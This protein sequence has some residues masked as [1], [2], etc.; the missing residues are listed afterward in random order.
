MPD[1]AL[2]CAAQFNSVGCHLCK[3]HPGDICVDPGDIFFLLGGQD[4]T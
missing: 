3:L 1:P 2:C 4:A